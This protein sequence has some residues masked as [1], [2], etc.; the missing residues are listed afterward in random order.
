MSAGEPEDWLRTQAQMR[1]PV[2]SSDGRNWL[3]HKIG[4]Q[5]ALI[6]QM[7]LA[8]AYSREEIAQALKDAFG[9]RLQEQQRRISSHFSHLTSGWNGKYA[10]HGLRITEVNGKC[11]FGDAPAT[12]SRAAAEALVADEDEESAFP[13]GRQRYRQHRHLERDS[14][15][16]KKAKAKRLAE[17]GKLECEVCS[18]DFTETYGALGIGFIEAHHTTPVSRLDGTTRT[19]VANLALVCSNCHRMLH[20][21]ADLL[22]IGELKSVFS[23]LAM[24]RAHEAGCPGCGRDC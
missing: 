10:P 9:G 1:R 13:E 8:G 3:R 7:L 16:V 24:K 11:R 14:A 2:S 17:T 5:G 20:R 23:N 22:S 18:F 21:A 19:S 4:G 15:I 12:G 6:D